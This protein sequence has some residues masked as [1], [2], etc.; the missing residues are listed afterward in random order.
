MAEKL[1]NDTPNIYY[2]IHNK[3]CWYLNKVIS[4]ITNLPEQEL[5]MKYEELN[6]E[7]Y[8]LGCINR[9]LAKWTLLNKGID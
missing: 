1:L 5:L 2:Q 8:I 7:P 4:E 6:V 3:I 9:T